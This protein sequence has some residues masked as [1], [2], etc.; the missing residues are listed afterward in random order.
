MSVKEIGTEEY[1]RM[2]LR[3]WP[4][5]ESKDVGSLFQITR[6]QGVIEVQVQPQRTSFQLEYFKNDQLVLSSTGCGEDHTFD[7]KPG[8]NPVTIYVCDAGGGRFPPLDLS[9]DQNSPLYGPRILRLLT[10]REYQRTITSLTGITTDVVSDFPKELR[11]HGFDNQ[12]ANG[13]V[14]D[15]HAEAHY[16]AAKIVSSTMI[17]KLS[18]YVACAQRDASCAGEFIRSFGKKAWRGPLNQEESAKLLTLFQSGANFDDGL[19]RVIQGLLMA[20]RFLYRFELGALKGSYY[21][22]SSWEMAQALSYMFWGMPPDDQLMALADA[23]KLTDKATIAAEA[24]RL[25]KDAKAKENLG[26]FTSSWLGT[27]SVLGVNKDAVLFPAF[28]SSLRR[29]AYDETNDFFTDVVTDKNGSFA[30]LFQS[31]YTIGD[32]ALSSLYDGV[33]T[34]GF[35]RYRSPERRG[36]LGHAS[37]LATYAGNDNSEPIKRGVFVLERLLCQVVPPPPP[38]LK[39][40]PP[41]RDP[42]ASVRERFASHSTNPS[43]AICHTRIDGIGFGMEDMDA[44][45]RF[46]QSDAGRPVDARGIVFG[47]GGEK[48][49]FEGTAALGRFLATSAQAESCMS[50]QVYR[51]AAGQDNDKKIACAVRDLDSAFVS[52]G[53]RV[54]TIFLQVPTL[55]AF[56]R[57]Q[58]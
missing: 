49:M 18:S 20:P 48:N 53:K 33:P 5:G 1:D 36:L 28:D 9:C 31:E 24:K 43:C 39:I 38:S 34:G 54:S 35:I 10:A 47:P 6:G 56:R 45:G 22:L 7:L 40:T 23:G 2:E 13:L 12:E 16:R 32:G 50:K 42:N 58:P 4:A 44:I 37:I 46:K 41:P 21:E 52:G 26:Y 14:T 57:R 8:P 29:K 15:A 3:A 17:K 19:E 51:F 11:S 27:E 25:W 30:D 55:D